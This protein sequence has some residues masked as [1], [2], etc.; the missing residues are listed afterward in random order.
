MKTSTI[1]TVLFAALC[2]FILPQQVKAQECGGGTAYGSSYALFDDQTQTVYGY[3]ATELDYCAGLYYDPYVEGYL[4]EGN[5]P[6]VAGANLGYAYV[7][8]AEVDTS[9]A[10]RPSTQYTVLS[11]HYVVAYYYY[12][13]NYNYNFYDP[14]GYNS[15]LQGGDYG[16]WNNFWSGFS[17]GYRSYQY[18]YLGSTYDQTVTP[19]E[20]QMTSSGAAYSFNSYYATS[21][22]SCQEVSVNIVFGGTG[23]PLA[24]GNPQGG[25]VRS[26]TMKAVGNLNEGSYYWSTTSNKVRLTNVTSDTV[27]VTSVSQ[28]DSVNDVNIQVQ[29]TVSSLPPAYAHISTTVQRPTSMKKIKDVLADH[30]KNCPSGS[31]G[32]EKI[33]EWQLSDQFGNPIKLAIPTYDYLFAYKGRNGCRL[34]LEGTPPGAHTSRDGHWTHIYFFCTTLCVGGYC[35][36]EGYQ[37]YYSNGFTFDLPFIFECGKITVKGDGTSATP[38]K[39][40]PRRA[41]DFVQDFWQAAYQQEP[42][43]YSWQ[44]WTDSLTNAQAQGQILAQSKVMA[45]SILQSPNYTNLNKSDEDYVYDLYMT[46]LNREPDPGGFDFWLNNLQN[47]N[48]NGLDG[49]A[50]L[51]SAFEESQEFADNVNSLTP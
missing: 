2:C 6:I 45:R 50:Q 44:T 36:T 32:R 19:S 40:N 48:A 4:Y 51:L 34:S 11:D 46:Y 41:G 8:A 20:C 28:S 9:A 38:A 35:R 10:A 22:T 39:P 16:G 25:A 1:F 29:Y 12:Y 3:S 43:D 18:F 42:D 30:P 13:D 17:V 23:V 7:Y 47:N 14:F 31:A 21:N 49:R 37:R 24:N 5:V 15:F 27:T 26:V 33:I